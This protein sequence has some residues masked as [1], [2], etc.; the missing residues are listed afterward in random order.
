MAIGNLFD[1]ND[2]YGARHTLLRKAPTEIDAMVL[3]ADVAES[4]TVPSGARYLVFSAQADFWVNPG[5]SAAVPTT[6]VT[7]G[8]AAECNPVGWEVE[9]ESSISFISE[10]ANK[11]S[12]AIYK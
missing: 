6:E 5:G 8:S 2:P 3:A 11:I 1:T 12:I 7:D 9:A 4:Y 10:V